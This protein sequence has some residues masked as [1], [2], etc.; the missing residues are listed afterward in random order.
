SETIDAPKVTSQ[1]WF[2]EV[3]LSAPVVLEATRRL[4]VTLSGQ[5]FAEESDLVGVTILDQHGASIA[6]GLSGAW[7]GDKASLIA[8]QAVKL[9]L[10]NDAI[11]GEDGVVN[12]A[13]PGD[14]TFAYRFTP[15]T[16]FSLRA[17]W[18]VSLDEDAP[19]RGDFSVA[20]PF[21]VRGYPTGLESDDTGYYLRLQV[22][23][24]L[25]VEK[26]IADVSVTPFVFADMGEA[27]DNTGSSYDG[28]GRLA[29]AGAGVAVSIRDKVFADVF[30]AR[31]LLDAA[32][33]DAGHDWS[34]F[35]KAGVRF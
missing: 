12:V 29:S 25:P 32:G 22:E 3:S 13:L 23:Q 21:A 9:T 15:R 35:A 2:G 26:L 28:L 19:S 5:Y 4:S 27:F 34:V 33:Y 1:S 10:Y 14:L 8:S 24:A 16:A 6:A 31:P 20:S 30:V 18:Q 17:G 11:T 7:F